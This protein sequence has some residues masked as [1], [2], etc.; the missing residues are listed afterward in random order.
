[1]PGYSQITLNPVAERA[2]GTPQLTVANSPQS[3]NLVEGREFYA[4]QAVALDTSVSPA[5]LYVSDYLNNRVLAWKNAAGFTDGQKADLAIGQP[6]LVTTFPEGPNGAQ[7]TSIYY[8]GLTRPSGLAVDQ[9][10]NLYVADGGNNRV[11]RYPKTAIAAGFAGTITQLEP[12]LWI[13]QANVK[14]GGANNSSNSPTPTAQGLYLSNGGAP[15]ISSLA[16]DSSGNLWVIDTGNAR[17]L[18]FNATSLSGGGGGLT[19]D[20]VIGQTNFTQNSTAGNLSS[21]TQFMSPTTLAFDGNGNL[22]VGDTNPHCSQLPCGRVMMFPGPN[23]SS[24]MSAASDMAGV[25]PSGYKFPTGAALQTLFDQ[26]SVVYPSAIFFLANGAGMGVV[27][28]AYNRIMIFPTFANWGANNAPPAET[29]I[30]GQPNATC[31]AT[32]NGSCKAANNGNPLASASTLS[33]SSSQALIPGGVA[34]TGTDLY[35]ADSLNNR[36]LDLPQQGGTFAAAS[37]WLGQDFAYESAPDLIEGREFQFTGTVGN[38]TFSDAGMAIDNSSG[39]PH[40]Y[41]A[42]PYNNRVLGFKDLRTF[43]NVGPKADI[44]LGQGDFTTSLVNYPSGNANTPNKSGL[45]RPIGLLV[46]AQ[47]NLYVS[48]SLNGRVLRFPCPFA[49]AGLETNSSCTAHGSAPEPADLVLGQQNFNATIP[50]QTANNMGI[51]YGLAFSPSC[52]TPSQACASPN[53]LLVSDELFNRVLYIPT[54]NGTFVAGTDNGKAATTVFGQSGFNSSNAGNS[55]S[56]MNLPHH[57]SSDTSGLV[58]VADTGNNRVLIFGDPHS[59]GTSPTGATAAVAINGLSGPTGVYVSPVTGEI[60]VANT[61]NATSLRYANYQAVLLNSQVTYSQILEASGNFG[62]SP[63]AI[64]QDQYG[65]L[66]VADNAHRVAIYYPGMALCNGASF[67]PASPTTSA[68]PSA[69]C[70][71]QDYD[72]TLKQTNDVLVP[73]ALAPGA[74]A[75][76]FPC[77]GCQPDQFGDQAGVFDGSYPVPTTLSGVEVFVNGVSS[78]LYYVGPPIPP[79]HPVGQINFIVPNETPV[80][81]NGTAPCVSLPGYN[82]VDVQVVQMSTGQ[83]LGASQMPIN[84]VAPGAFPNPLVGVQTSHTFYA[85]AVNEDGNVNSASDPAVRGDWV[86][87]YMTGEGLVPGGPADGQPAT[88]AISAQY[89]ITVYINGIDVNDPAYQ[90]QNIQHILYS[91]VSA[92][93]GMWQINLQIPKTVVPTNGAVWF[94]VQVNNALNWYV[95]APFYT[96]IYV[97]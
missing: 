25:F 84:S 75:T 33:F 46:D 49:Y 48:D 9:N 15:L 12:D 79:S 7:G 8:G 59:P 76:I 40:L 30:V 95:D 73:R 64:A 35:V 61:G 28:A 88:G 50:D 92:F 14:S 3:P 17:I 18:R 58:Y 10:G 97:K 2:V 29:A 34:Y 21:Q 53:G 77:Q 69:G 60:W 44:V 13:G 36:V 6:D 63:L 5:I 66:F 39:T 74:V 27:D 42:D 62:F 32:A 89:P 96:Y 45:N 43:Q 20:T 54:T 86:S 83:V 47:G 68:A 65:D 26:T 90:E 55:L 11:L 56:Q 72:G 91:G 85:A 81:G 22:F 80:S 37:R 51:P 4:P 82:C 16:F 41:V 31:A 52:N 23:F 24:G 67:L 87:L 71:S 93:P 57:I 70:L 38:S 94:D 1:M 19:A 78:P